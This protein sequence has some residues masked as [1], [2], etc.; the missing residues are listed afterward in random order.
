MGGERENREK[1]QPRGRVSQ[2]RRKGVSK[3]IYHFLITSI[4]RFL[5]S[6][7]GDMIPPAKR[8][9]SYTS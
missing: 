6:E 3:A 1:M 2:E 4:Y 9:H 5:V 8:P 7:G